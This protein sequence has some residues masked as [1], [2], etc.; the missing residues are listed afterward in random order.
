[1]RPRA[2]A[3]GLVM[4]VVIMVVR[5]IIIVMV[6]IM[7]MCRAAVPDVRMMLAATIPAVGMRAMSA[8]APVR[9]GVLLRAAI[10]VTRAAGIARSV[11]ADPIRA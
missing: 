5:V 10:Y 3:A 4:S 2:G 9:A 1:M 11:P 7:M 8:S 6:V